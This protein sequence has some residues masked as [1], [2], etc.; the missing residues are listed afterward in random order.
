M[1]AVIGILNKNAAAVAADSAVTISG[2]G[3]SKIYNTANKIFTL[4][5][6]HPVGVMVYSSASFMGTPWEVIIKV[7]RDSLGSNSFDTLEEYHSDFIRFLKDKDYYSNPDEQKAFLTNYIISVFKALNNS[8][9]L[10]NKK[11]LADPDKFESEINDLISEEAKKYIHE[12]LPTFDE[13]SEFEGYEKEDFLECANDSIK[14][15]LKT[16]Y[17]DNGYSLKSSTVSMLKPL[18]FEHVKSQ[19]FLMYSGLVFVGFG[20]KEIYPQLTPLLISSVVD[21]RLRY[22]IDKSRSRYISNLEQPV[23]ICPFAQQDVIETILYGIDPDF[24]KVQEQNFSKFFNK[25][26]K[27]IV[28]KVEGDSP[29]LAEEIKNFDTNKL[30]KE[31]RESIQEVQ[32]NQ[33]AMPLYTAVSNLS[34]ED[35]AEMA[36]SLIN[37]TYLKRRITFNEESVGGPVDVALITKGDGFIWKKRKHYFDPKLNHHFFK[38]YLNHE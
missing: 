31:F 16:V 27:R 38:N 11:L 34:K 9:F 36:E 24:R 15:A 37:L 1:S 20:E 6:Y 8:A 33:Y 29:E 28:N 30:L 23:A 2:G 32:I 25:Y 19:N 3:D 12:T 13:C 7:Y 17:S 5:K 22:N 14:Q 10:N 35:L 26:K 4:S 18:V 21:G